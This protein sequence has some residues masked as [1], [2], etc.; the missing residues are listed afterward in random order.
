M[1]ADNTRISPKNISA[2]DDLV[3]NEYDIKWVDQNASW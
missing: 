1:T 2:L 3:E